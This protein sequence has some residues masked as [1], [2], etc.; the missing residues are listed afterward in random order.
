MSWRI[1]QLVL[2]RNVTLRWDHHLGWPFPHSGQSISWCGY[3][4]RVR[5]YA[6]LKF[7]RGP[8]S[9][10]LQNL[11]D[12]SYNGP[13]IFEKLLVGLPGK[14]KLSF[15]TALRCVLTDPKS[16]KDFPEKFQAEFI[17]IPAIPVSEAI[18]ETLGSEIDKLKLR[19]CCTDPEYLRLQNELKI[20]LMGPPPMVDQMLTKSGSLCK[21]V[22]PE[23][24]LRYK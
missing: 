15:N 18:A 3:W 17:G 7:L 1:Y 20:K 10:S 8:I 16:Y 6:V 9:H 2:L 12:T 19:Y 5:R 14:S 13:A 11:T 22:R 23:N 24:G 21:H 4:W